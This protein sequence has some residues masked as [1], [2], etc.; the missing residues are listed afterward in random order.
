MSNVFIACENDFP[1]EISRSKA[2]G[3]TRLLID[4]DVKS[5][6]RYEMKTVGTDLVISAIESDEEPT[7][8]TFLCKEFGVD[9]GKRFDSDISVIFLDEGY[10]LVTL[11]KGAI[12]F[13]I[14]DEEG[15]INPLA[16]SINID[17]A[18]IPKF[19][20]DEIL[21]VNIEKLMSF[22]RYFREFKPAFVFDFEFSFKVGGSNAG[23]ETFR[24]RSMSEEDI[25]I[26]LGKYALYVD[27]KRK[28]QELKE[29]SKLVKM[30]NNT[31][32]DSSLDFDDDEDDDEGLEFDD[33]DEE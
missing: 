33:D 31:G 14:E 32:A 9:E 25:D 28:Q 11:K 3:H 13:M 4:K 1:R 30:F 24:F 29:A 23:T 26:S 21:W 27:T 22:S 16:P 19:K 10:M 20:P 17:S 15:K 18:S 12:A 5:F 7:S 6:G 2:K 8:F